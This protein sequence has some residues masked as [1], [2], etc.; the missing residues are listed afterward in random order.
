MMPCSLSDHMFGFPVILAS[1]AFYIYLEK[2][3]PLL[4]STLE[5]LDLFG[6]LNPDGLWIPSHGA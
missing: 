4:C 1:H 6:L 2:L 3:C 5:T